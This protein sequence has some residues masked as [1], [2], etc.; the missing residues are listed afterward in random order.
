MFELA[1]D[2]EVAFTSTVKLLFF[3]WLW[4][5]LKIASSFLVPAAVMACTRQLNIIYHSLGK[6]IHTKY[7][8]HSSKEKIDREISK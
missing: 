1:F 8:N 6:N 4:I 5:S 3:S 7:Y 2:S